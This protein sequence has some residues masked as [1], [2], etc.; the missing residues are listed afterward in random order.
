LTKSDDKA[1]ILVGMS[2][3]DDL[4]PAP[5][6]FVSK[7]YAESAKN[8]HALDFEAANLLSL[9]KMSE[10]NIDNTTVVSQLAQDAKSC[11]AI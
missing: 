11:L 10:K 5:F 3:G 6:F 2:L 4:R 1:N 8:S 7:N 9:N